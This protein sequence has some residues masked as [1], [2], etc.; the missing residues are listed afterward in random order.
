MQRIASGLSLTATGLGSYKSG[1]ELDIASAAKFNGKIEVINK[2]RAV[3]VA[4]VMRSYAINY[5][6]TVGGVYFD[7]VDITSVAAAT[8]SL[9][10]NFDATSLATLNAKVADSVNLQT[11]SSGKAFAKFYGTSNP[12]FI[13]IPNSADM[14]FEGEAT[15]DLWTRVDSRAGMNGYGN[16]VTS[17]SVMAL[18]AK[19]H[20]RVGA[21]LIT[22][23]AD[24][25]YPDSGYGRPSLAS[26]D[27]SW[28]CGEPTLYSENPGVPL[29]TWYRLT[30]SISSTAGYA[31]YVNGVAVKICPN[32]RPNFAQMNGQDLYIGMYSDGWYPMNG[33]IRDV[34]IYKSALTQAQI[35]VLQ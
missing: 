5:L 27:T 17:G 26:F 10:I 9:T 35:N 22:H 32:A 25:K 28:A 11:D 12:G 33:A 30:V 20:D 7:V 18:I 6:D 24:P 2:A 4:Q 29:N 8:P 31:A 13:R 21:S 3:A 23:D 1:L 15:F 34:R 16:V 14:Q 19:S